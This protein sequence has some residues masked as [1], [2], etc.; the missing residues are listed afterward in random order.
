MIPLINPMFRNEPYLIRKY[1]I[2]NFQFQDQRLHFMGTTMSENPQ[3]YIS[4]VRQKYLLTPEEK[5]RLL[6]QKYFHNDGFFFF[7]G[8]TGSGKTTLIYFLFELF[9]TFYPEKK[10]FVRNCEIFQG[11]QYLEDFDIE[12]PYKTL[13]PNS[14]L[15]HDEVHYDIPPSIPV[16]SKTYINLRKFISTKRHR[17][18]IIFQISQSTA[19]FHK[20]LLRYTDGHIYLQTSIMTELERPEFLP[21]IEKAQSI[22]EQDSFNFVFLNDNDI[23]HIPF[24]R[25]KDMS[26]KMSFYYDGGQNEQ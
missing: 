19:N 22:I 26:D 4:L 7:C 25:H 5:I 15:F 10:I 16:T 14:V 11:M 21:Y 24:F 2:E 17:R 8:R 20:D 13:P 12:Q 6:F 1:L 23:F 9:K 3:F 18:Q